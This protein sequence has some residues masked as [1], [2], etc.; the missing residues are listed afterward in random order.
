MPF[1]EDAPTHP[2]ANKNP[3]RDHPHRSIRSEGAV[4]RVYPPLCVR[5]VAHGF[6]NRFAERSKVAQSSWLRCIQHNGRRAGAGK[7]DEEEADNLASTLKA[8]GYAT[9]GGKWHVSDEGIGNLH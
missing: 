7:L 2:A 1:W 3:D 4:P 8:A 6:D 9:Q 5:L